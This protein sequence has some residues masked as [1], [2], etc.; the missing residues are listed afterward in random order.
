MRST[1][2][3]SQNAIK[4]VRLTEDVIEVHYGDGAEPIYI[5]NDDELY[6][7]HL[8]NF[9]TLINNALAENTEEVSNDNKDD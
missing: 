8:K 4:T 5:H 2:L 6:E 1:L 9:R 7:H 3:F